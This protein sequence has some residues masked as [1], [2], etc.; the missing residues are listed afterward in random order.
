M[1]IA[2]FFD[3]GTVWNSRGINPQQQTISSFG[4]GLLWQPSRDLNL[5]L[6]Y[7]IPLT[8]VSTGGNT[9]QDNGLTF[10]LRYQAF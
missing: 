8:D 4:L 5:R 3:I 7:G 9:L 2:P 6:D 10:S 1:Q